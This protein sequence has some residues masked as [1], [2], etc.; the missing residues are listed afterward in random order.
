MIRLLQVGSR[1]LVLTFCWREW[2]AQRGVLI[3]YTLLGLLCLCLGFSMVPE[4][5]WEQRGRRAMALSWFVA[6]GVIGVVAFVAPALVRGEY[7][8]KNDQFVRRLP[9][10]LRASFAG[11]LL[12]LVLATAAL[13]LLTVLVGQGF[14]WAIDEPWHR[15]L[16]LWDCNG[17]IFFEWPWPAVACGYALLLMPWVW[18]IGTWLPSGRMALG[19]TILMTLVIGV[20]IFAVLRQ[21]PGIEKGIAWQGWL[22]AVPVVGLLAAF[23]S[24]TK[25]RRGGGALRS[26]RFGLAATA[27]G[28]VPPSLWLAERTWHYHHPDLQHLA[29]VDVRG[30]SPDGQFALVEGAAN[31][32]FAQVALRV[33]LRDGS[34][35]QLAG[36]CGRRLA[37]GCGF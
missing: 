22:W 28:L 35:T 20:G 26:A 31:E 17:N 13:P 5:W 14:L 37:S 29:T 36:C 18:A 16:F 3:A 1:S 8:S 32:N 6:L 23:A 19:G 7:G 4:H 34:A 33:D 10:A 27:V 21:S 2:R 30:V 9:G 15:D 11:K 24:W 25:G 12:F